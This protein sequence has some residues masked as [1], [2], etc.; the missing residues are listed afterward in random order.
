MTSRPGRPTSTASLIC[1]NKSPFPSTTKSNFSCP[2]SNFKI[3]IFSKSPKNLSR[4]NNSPTSG[5]SQFQPTTTFPVN[6]GTSTTRPSCN[7]SNCKIKANTLSIIIIISKIMTVNLSRN[8][9][10]LRV[11]IT[12]LSSK[13]RNKKTTS[14]VIKLS[15]C[16]INSTTLI[17]ARVSSCSLSL[18]TAKFCK[19]MRTPNYFS[20]LIN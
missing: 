15:L 16:K 13:P 18:Q 14:R 8:R 20:F 7:N 6:C 2:A 4:S 19:L 3:Q 9:P 17:S 10:P 11:I 5:L 1:K 12:S